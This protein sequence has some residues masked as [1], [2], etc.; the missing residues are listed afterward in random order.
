MFVATVFTVQTGGARIAPYEPPIQHD[1]SLVVASEDSLEYTQYEPS[2]QND[3]SPAVASEGSMD[4]TTDSSHLIEQ[5]IQKFM[6]GWQKMNKQDKQTF[7]EEQNIQELKGVNT[8]EDDMPAKAYSAKIYDNIDLYSYFSYLYYYPTMQWFLD[9]TPDTD[10]Y[11]VGIYKVGDSDKNYLAHQWLQRKAQGS[12]KIG[13]L[14][15][16]SR[17]WKR[18]RYDKF[19]LRLFKGKY[20]RVD[21]VT[22]ILH[23]RVHSLPAEVSSTARAEEADYMP[24]IEPKLQTFLSALDRVENLNELKKPLMLA[25]Y[26]QENFNDVW[27]QF[28]LNEQQLLLPILK[29]DSIFPDVKKADPQVYGRLEPKVLYPDLGEHCVPALMQVANPAKEPTKITLTI[30]LD[31]SYTCV[32]PVINTKKTLSGKYSWLGVYRKKE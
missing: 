5:R 15:S 2:F 14:S 30:Q 22:N 10:N 9:K 20:K 3:D 11:W 23:G 16:K 18:N 28:D 13:Q 17:S 31:G 26:S 7:I 27:S 4:S 1:D 29:Q 12:Y 24:P 32:Y 25:Q 19:E 8:E 21:A 6:S